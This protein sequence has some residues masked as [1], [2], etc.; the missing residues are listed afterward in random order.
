MPLTAAEIRTAKPNKKN[1]K[2]SDEKGLYLLVTPAGSKLWKLKFRVHGKEKKLSLGSYPEIGLK[3]ARAKRDAARAELMA[4]VDPARKKQ[5]RKIQEKLGVAHSFGAIGQEYLDKMAQEGKA[6]ATMQKAKWLYGQLTPTLGKR[7]IADITPAELLAVLKRVEGQGKRET[8]RRLRSFAG[9]VFRYAIATDRTD[10]DPTYSLRGAL[11]VPQ[12]KHLAAITDRKQLG[13]LLRAIDGYNGQPATQTALRLTPHVFQRPGEIRKMEWSELNLAEAIWT[14][15]ASKMKKREPHVVP[16]S[17]QSVTLLEEAR[18][19]H[20]RSTYVFPALGKPLKPM[21][22]NAVVGALRR[23]GYGG[24]EM[25]AHGFRTTA[26]S[27]L[28]ESGKWNPD[29]IERALSH[30]DRDQI[31]GIYN[32][33]AYWDER[34]EM[35]QWWSDFLD[36][37]NHGAEIVDIRTTVER[38]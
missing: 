14:I 11:L 23:L 36:Q 19:L 28:N 38:G 22:E 5:E 15:P 24:N 29:A 30:S 37:L 18:E 13:E 34:V 4:G 2:L 25:S 1:R 6:P 16:L 3:Q 20:T 12:V 9:R 31:R 17:C 33:S 21:S 35:A 7:P 27:L 8:A 32:R 10:T 26:S